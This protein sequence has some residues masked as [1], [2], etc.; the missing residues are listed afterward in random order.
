ML[1]DKLV[2][3]MV[4]TSPFIRGRLRH[5]ISSIS[6]ITTPT[7]IWCW[8]T[9]GKRLKRFF[10]IQISLTPE[11]YPSQKEN[12]THGR[13]DRPA[14]LCQDVRLNSH[15]GQGLIDHGRDGAGIVEVRMDQDCSDWPDQRR[16][17]L[18]SA[19]SHFQTALSCLRAN[20]GCYAV[21]PRSKVTFRTHSLG[22]PSWHRCKIY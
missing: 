15:V 8:L 2:V 5:L 12:H 22:R 13:G 4:R 14:R 16:S 21:S 11:P 3:K 18:T 19:T 9:T 7:T 1:V 6:H 20:V 17:S 10:L